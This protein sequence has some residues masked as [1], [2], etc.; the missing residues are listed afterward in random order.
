MKKSLFFILTFLLFISLHAQRNT[1]SNA[2][3]FGAG[4][5]KSEVHDL[6]ELWPMMEEQDTVD[7][8]ITGKV[9]DVCQKKGCWMHV[10]QP[11][12]DD[13]QLMVQFKDY[14]FFMPL[15]IADRQVVIE[16][17]AYR[18]ITPVDEL[19]HYA[20]DAGKSKEEIEAITEPKEEI[21][22]MASGVKVY[23]AK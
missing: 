1:A 21:K 7:I 15:D 19:R 12:M 4:I 17:I 18:N 23:P 6:D 5:T 2:Q 9:V 8:A 20:E 14:A 3:M 22:F 11:D 13:K 10:Y 16:G